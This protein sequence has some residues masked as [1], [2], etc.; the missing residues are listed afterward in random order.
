MSKRSINDIL[1]KTEISI[2]IALTLLFVYMEI[3]RGVSDRL[4]NII[5]CAFMLLSFGYLYALEFIFPKYD[6]AVHYKMYAKYYIPTG[7]APKKTYKRKGI[8]CV[9]A[10]WVA[11]LAFIYTLKIFG[12]L[13]WQLYLVGA[14][15]MFI[16][17]S[18]FT[19][20]WCGLSKLFLHN[21][22][23]CCKNCG[24]NSWDYAIFASSLIFAP[25]L[26]AAATIL[27]YLIILSSLFVLIVWEYNYHKYPHRFY[28]ETNKRL[29]CANCLKKCK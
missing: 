13:S 27:N 10:L 11:Y 28:P 9:I 21:K 14:C 4:A 29:S 18:V 15:I 6:N 2:Y 3:W 7:I 25:K 17:N 19:R 12:I 8:I 1:L 5:Y 20:K 26:S 23:D 16:L 22:N 24:I